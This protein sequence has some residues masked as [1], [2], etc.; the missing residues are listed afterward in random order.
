LSVRN[1]AS[2]KSFKPTSKERNKEVRK[3][4]WVVVLMAFAVGLTQAGYLTPTLQAKADK[5]APGELLK[6]IV[7][8]DREADI[9]A[10]PSGPWQAKARYL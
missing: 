7:R 8:M 6:I 2:G 3:L 1:K 5:A 4:F 9:S 10:L